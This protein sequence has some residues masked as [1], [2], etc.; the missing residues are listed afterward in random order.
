MYIYI[1]V[2]MCIT[3]IYIYSYVIELLSRRQVGVHDGGGAPRVQVDD[4]LEKNKSY[5]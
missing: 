2:Y 4:G 1:Y 3:Y 5:L